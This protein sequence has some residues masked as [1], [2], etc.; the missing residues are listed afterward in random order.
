MVSNMM[1]ATLM[2]ST[3]FAE[4]V[5]YLNPK[6]KLPSR[7]KYMRCIVKTFE[8]VKADLISIFSGLKYVATTGWLLKF[9]FRFLD[10][11]SVLY[12]PT[13]HDFTS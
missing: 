12:W 9:C 10:V 2:E 5:K 4:F 7:R 11:V 13:Q 8:E 1:P 3:S 6:F